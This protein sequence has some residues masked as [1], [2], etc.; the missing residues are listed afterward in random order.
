MYYFHFYPSSHHLSSKLLYSPVGS[1]EI[2]PYF[3]PTICQEFFQWLPTD[4]K[5]NF[6]LTWSIKAYMVWPLLASQVFSLCSSDIHSL[7]TPHHLLSQGCH[8]TLFLLNT[9]CFSLYQVNAQLHFLREACLDYSL[10]TTYLSL[11]ALV[12]TKIICM[13]FWS[14]LIN[15]VSF[16]SL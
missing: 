6:S 7:N 15:V 9:L 10:L 8:N 4:I 1:T 16:T 11:K 5:I 14:D 3:S 13:Y 12:T 2:Y